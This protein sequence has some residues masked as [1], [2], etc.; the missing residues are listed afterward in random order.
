MTNKAA[1]D[2]KQIA[3]PIHDCKKNNVG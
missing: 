1:R 2:L 3:L